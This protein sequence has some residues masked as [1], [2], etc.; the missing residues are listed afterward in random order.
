[1][2]LLDVPATPPAPAPMGGAERRLTLTGI[3]WETYVHLN[4]GV[5]PG[6][7][8]TYDR[9]KMEIVT[10]SE[11]HEIVKT[12]L[13]RIIEGYSDAAGIDAEG[14]G[15]WTMRR[16]DLARGLEPDECYYVAHAALVLSLRGKRRLDLSIDPPPDL[17]IEVDVS[18]PEVAKAPIYAALGVPE[19][20][21]YDGRAVTYLA[22]QPDGE[23]RVIDRSLSFPGLPLDCVNEALAIGLTQGERAAAAEVRRRVGGT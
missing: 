1:M 12:C 13:A 7:R 4:D 10:L 11:L 21:R 2:T 8:I 16:R 22:R 15:G 14:L 6:T 3:S 19:I 9:G 18:P 23:Y 5:G 17:A 20:W